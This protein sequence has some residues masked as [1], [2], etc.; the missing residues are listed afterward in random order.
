MQRYLAGVGTSYVRMFANVLVGL[1]LTPFTL[2]YLDREQFAIFSLIL[3]LLVWL[4]LLDFGITAGLR[5]QA[6]R[7][8]GGPDADKLNRLASTAFF[9]QNLIVL[10]IMVAGTGLALAFPHFFEVR[11][12]LQRE[13]MFV[14]LLLVLGVGLSIGTQTFSALLI[15]HQQIHIDNL[16]GLLQTA[17][18]TVVT[19]VM[20]YLG[21]GLYSL[22]IAH[23]AS[24]I[25]TAVLAV[26]RTFRLLPGLRIS[27]RLVS[28]D[29]MSGTAS[30]GVWFTLGSLAAI[31]IDS[32]NSTVTAK[33]LSVETVASLTLT[34]RFYE[35]VG[36]LVVALAE[37]A[38]PLLGQMLGQNQ[39]AEALTAYRR[40][41]SISTSLAV[42]AALSVW[43][44]NAC[45][46][47]RWVGAAN[48]AGTGADLVL[49]FSVLTFNWIM[50]NRAILAANLELRAQSLTRI[51]EGALNV[52]LAVWLGKQFGLV[53][54]L[55][56]GLLAALLTSMWIL[57]L[58]TARMFHRS[59]LRF[60]WEDAARSLGV[61]ALL[62]PIAWIA[63]GCALSVG[64]YAGAIVGATLTG[65]CGLGWFWFLI[66]DA[67]LRTRLFNLG[68]QYG[69]G[70][71]GGRPVGPQC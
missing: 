64:G 60:L 19:V 59:F 52:T 35:L 61:L 9:A 48:Y 27:Y 30:L 15:A 40:L 71:L 44:G 14:C 12:E 36:S 55:L 53:G 68:L 1:W 25:I 39:N 50:P 38:R 57:P 37:T 45:F 51:V 65:L 34:S 28:W 22:A 66:L 11:P 56:G 70:V 18:R 58:L 31:L 41:F 13:A 67:P 4:G 62:F 43:S 8:A 23:L 69:R 7:L 17:I 16:I 54:I 63:R 24:K 42:V 20:L 49:A 46:V 6:A 33:V 2:R 32:L 5:I 26:V 21:W 47:R 3:S 29:T 10:A